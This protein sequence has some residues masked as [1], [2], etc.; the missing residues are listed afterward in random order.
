MGPNIVLVIA[1]NKSDLIKRCQVDLDEAKSYAESVGAVHVLVSAKTNKN[2]EQAFLEVTKQMLIQD[3]KRPD[4]EK[5]AE[6]NN[7]T[8]IGISNEMEQTNNGGCC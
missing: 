8:L 2:V 1:G 3:S 5:Q 4:S 7:R 6:N